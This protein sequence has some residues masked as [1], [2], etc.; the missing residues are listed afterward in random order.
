M[1]EKVFCFPITPAYNLVGFTTSH[2]IVHVSVCPLSLKAMRSARK[3][4]K[5][6]AQTVP[7]RS[8]VISW[9]RDYEAEKNLETKKDTEIEKMEKLETPVDDMKSAIVYGLGAFLCDFL[10]P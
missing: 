4:A 7:T 2:Y 5:K 3:E 1:G 8:R 6:L 10:V 9:I